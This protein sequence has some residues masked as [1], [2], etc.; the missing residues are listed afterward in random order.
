M[1]V[2]AVLADLARAYESRTGRRVAFASMGGVDAAARVR[3]GEAFDVAVLARDAIDGLIAEGHLASGSR[4]DLVRSQVAVAVRAGAARPDISSEDALRR[5]VQAAPSIGVSTG[6]SGAGLGRL[7][8]RWHIASD[9]QGRIVT[10]PPGVP[11][12]SLVARG[13]VSLGFQQL[14][15]LLPL[16]GVDVLGPMPEAVRIVSVFSAAVGARSQRSEAARALLAFLSSPE[17]AAA[18]RRHGMEPP[19][20]GA[21]DGEPGP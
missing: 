10:P 4:V 5:A 3:A 12:G 6:P 16:E 20:A 11:V 1:A 19:E 13:E 9:L 2:K 14:S 17:A 18:K 7:F 8:E 21:T 15:E